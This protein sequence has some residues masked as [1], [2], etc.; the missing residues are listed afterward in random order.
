MSSGQ[1]FRWNAEDGIV[2]LGFMPAPFDDRSEPSAVSNDGQVVVGNGFD[3]DAKQFPRYGF[4]WTANEGIVPIGP[5]PAQ[6]ALDGTTAL[7]VSGDGEV[8]AGFTDVLPGTRS[9]RWTVPQ[10]IVGIPLPF[11]FGSGVS[12]DGRVLIGRTNTPFSFGAASWTKAGGTR[13]LGDLPGGGEQGEA[14][15]VSLDGSV[16]VGISLSAES[17]PSNYEAFRWTEA[18]GMLGLGDLPGGLFRSWARAVSDDGCVVVG[19]SSVDYAIPGGN[20]DEAFI[21]DAQHGMRRLFDVLTNDYGMDLTGWYLRSARGISADGRAICGYGVNPE[22]ITEAWIAYLDGP[23]PPPCPADFNADSRINSQDF[24]DYLVAFFTA[25]P[26]CNADPELICLDPANFNH[27]HCVN[28]QDF[29]DF[30]AAFLA[31]C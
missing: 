4:R 27:D 29:F 15:A 26:C 23:P 16:I 21:W 9:F 24:F 1:A 18:T 28:S 11:T 20:R 19:D 30:L 25:P 12:R 13:F 7:G 31:G 2:F 5:P 14:T 3:Y 10:G 6:G 8:V 22:G 17:G